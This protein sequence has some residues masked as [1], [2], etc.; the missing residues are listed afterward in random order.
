MTMSLHALLSSETFSCFGPFSDVKWL[1]VMETYL[2]VQGVQIC[3]SAGA[4][5]PGRG[6]FSQEIFADSK[7]K[8][9]TILQILRNVF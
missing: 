6:T 3:G 1:G 9:T 2:I 7:K 8:F 4:P 5:L